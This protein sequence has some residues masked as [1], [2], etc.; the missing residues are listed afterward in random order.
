MKQALGTVTNAF[1]RLGDQIT[2]LESQSLDMKAAGQ[3]RQ[4][5]SNLEKQIDK[6]KKEV[7]SLRIS[8]QSKI[9]ESVEEKIRTELCDVIKSSVREQVE[10]RVRQQL[11]LQIPDKLRKEVISHKR[12]ILE[13][14]T[15]LHNSE[16]RRY[17]AL[18]TI[19]D[20]KARLRPLLRPLPTPE[21]SP[22]IIIS[23]F[24][25]VA[26]STM[27]TPTSAYPNHFNYKV[28]APTPIKRVTS[29]SL[30]SAFIPDT[31]PPT[32]SSLF[33]RDLAALFAL[34]QEDTKKLL[35]EYG[36]D[37][38]VSSPVRPR[39]RGLSIV[40][41]ED[42]VFS[43]S[44]KGGGEEEE[45]E[46]DPDAHAQDMN[47]FMAH[48]GVPFLMIPAPKEKLDPTAPMSAKSRRKML[49]PLIIK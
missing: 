26:N 10:E 49:T 27:A 23:H 21:Q 25:S 2:T 11:T 8:L 1:D 18:Q 45:D 6:H 7:E 43:D 31:V 24:D 38:A 28:P 22:V 13:L 44:E 17:N 42:T 36:L 47:K 30:R 4:L 41:E 35:R 46:G 9:K 15:S 14:K 37:S 5:Q 20:P 32:P 12:Q 34:S 29:S 3:L 19:P 40:N 48:I 16:A 33:P 39:P